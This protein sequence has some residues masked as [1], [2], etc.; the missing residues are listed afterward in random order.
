MP[1]DILLR[2]LANY[3]IGGRL[4]KLISNYLS[5][6]QQ[7]V[8][9]DNV[10]SSFLPVTSGVPQGSCLAPKFFLYFIN[11][12]PDI[13]ETAKPYLFADDVKL[14]LQLDRENFF[15]VVQE[16][17]SKLLDWTVS[18]RMEL[19]VPKCGLLF[20]KKNPQIVTIQKS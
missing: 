9:A 6:R 15:D 3:G 17:T 4:L 14:L 2:K 16:E 5:E 12:L 10:K 13:F 20:Y 19:S 18:N 8:K 1:H 7:F 11:D